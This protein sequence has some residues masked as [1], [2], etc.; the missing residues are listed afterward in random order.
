MNQQQ[1]EV[2]IFE[3]PNS[4]RNSEEMSKSIFSTVFAIIYNFSWGMLFLIFRH[5]NDSECQLIDS[6][7]QY[8][9]IVLFIIAGYK[10]F[11]ELPI[12]Y[13]TNI[14]W[15][16][17]LFDVV[18]YLELFFNIVILIGLTY[19]YLQNEECYNLK[20]FVLG[21]LIVT[22]LILLI[23]LISFIFIICNREQFSRNQ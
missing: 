19:A 16:N 14:Q 9:E 10:L 3:N 1:E 2:E 7:T 22:Y 8:T 12:Q 18:D 11:I 21:Y 17:Q 5:Y 6:W 20:R 23:W 4:N 15:K 13:Q